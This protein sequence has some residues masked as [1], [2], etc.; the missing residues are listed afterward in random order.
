MPSH[1]S[2]LSANEIDA[3]A[4]IN[5]PGTSTKRAKPPSRTASSTKTDDVCQKQKR[6]RGVEEK[7]HIKPRM[8]SADTSN[9]TTPPNT[10]PETARSSK[11][12]KKPVTLPKALV[13]HAAKATPVGK[14]L[15]AAQK[16]K[17]TPL[18]T[19]SEYAKF[20]QAK[21][22]EKMK[23]GTPPIFRA[24]KGKR[25]FFS[26]GDYSAAVESTRKKMDMV[27]Q[28]LMLA[29]ITNQQPVHRS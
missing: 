15:T 7:R 19:P 1:P 18:Y 24:L 3:R 23:N 9:V 14:R 5:V 10:A 20:I 8:S 26:G 21:F 12:G 25:F 29:S 4:K 17:Q 22:A 16:R 2:A 28:Q 6:P 11:S 27:R 13:P